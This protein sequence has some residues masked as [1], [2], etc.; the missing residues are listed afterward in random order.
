VSSATQVTL[1]AQSQEN[2]AQKASITINVCNPAVQVQVVPFYTT[3]YSGQPADVQSFVWGSANRNVTWAITSQPNGGDGTLSDTA[4]LDASFT[5]T[6]AGRYTL[7][8]TS[9]A[10]PTQSNTATVYVTGH[11]MSYSVT[12]NETVPVDCTVDPALTGTTYDVGPS[13]A[14][15]TIQSVPWT[16]MTAGSTVRIHNED[17]TGSSPT[18]YHEYFQ[19]ITHA[20]RTQPVRVCGV[21]D[22]RGNLPVVDANNSTGSSSVDPYSAGYTAIGVGQTGWHLYTGNWTSS[23]YLIVE[24]LRV[25]NAKKTSTYTTPAGVAGAVWG[26]GAAC[27]RLYESMNTVVRGI[28][29]FNCGDGFFSDFNANNGFF[30]VENT[31]YEGNHL[32]GN[33]NPGSYSEHQFYIQGWNEVVQF[34]VIDQYESGAAGSNF[35]S[36]GFPDVIR[37][38][39][40][41]DGAARQLDLV[42]NQDATPYAT[43]EAYL[44]YYLATYPSDAYT[45]DLLAAAVEAH[46]ADYVYGNTFVNTSSSLAIHYATDQCDLEGDRIG[47]LWFYNN[48]FYEGSNSQWRWFLFDTS[49]GGGNDCPEVEWPQLQIDNNAFWMD[50]PTQPYFSW[51]YETNSFVSFGTNVVNSNWGSGNLAGG[52]GTGWALRVSPYAFQGASNSD[53][54]SGVSNFVGASSDPF[55]TTTFEPNSSLVNTGSVLPA[56]GPKLPVR[57]QFGPSAIPTVRVQ[58]LTVGAME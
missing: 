13:Q 11:S 33:G 26:Q 36:R 32:H 51:N 42:D 43:F 20:G 7:T 1:T 21:P 50:S 53:D 16:T 46:H 49:A 57:F 55:N 35:K 2:P 19:V 48:S 58:P 47:T 31:L 9:V 8:A 28:D 17:T 39:N 27:V 25:Q 41:G 56:N 12:P 3:V 29:A 14:Y 15:K 54:I 6:V 24:G 4:N 22:A 38:N 37:Y 18:T 30:A 10:D 44:G 52:D 45:A 40:F 5:A 23:Q 34:N